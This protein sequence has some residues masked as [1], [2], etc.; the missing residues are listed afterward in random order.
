M[1][2]GVENHILIGKQNV[3]DRH[4]D[5]CLMYLQIQ[6]SNSHS[7]YHPMFYIASFSTLISTIR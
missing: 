4:P 5:K 3:I 6:L 1:I 7:I 2:V